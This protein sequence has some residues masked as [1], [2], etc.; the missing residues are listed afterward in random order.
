[1]LQNFRV[2][3]LTWNVVGRQPI[4]DLQL[5][6]GLEDPIDPLTLPD[7]YIVGLQE[8]SSK[9][10]DRVIDLLFDDPWA[11]AIKQILHP[12]DY[13]KVK[14]VRLQGIILLFFCKRTHLVHLRRTQT[15][16]TRTGF[17][18]VWG[19]KGG[20]SIRF[21]VYSCSVCVVNCHFAPH[22]KELQQRIYEYNTIVDSQ[23]FD[24]PQ[25]KNILMHDYV[26]WMGDLNF[27]IDDMLT[28]EMKL[29]IEREEFA[30]L[31]AKDQLCQIR[32]TGEAFSEFTEETPTF[33][34]TYRFIIDSDEYDYLNRRPAWTDRILY[35]FTQ[36]AYDQVS[37]DLE[38]HHYK[39]YPY[40]LQSDHK[41]VSSAFSIKVFS[42]PKEDLIIFL[43]IQN[44]KINTDGIACYK[45]VGAD[46]NSWDWIALYRVHFS[47]IDEY[48]CYVWASTKPLVIP[49]STPE[50]E[51]LIVSTQENFTRAH[52]AWLQ[53]QVTF[54]DHNILL[55]GTYQ[56]LY[57][58]SSFDN[59]LGMSEPFEILRG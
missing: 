36:N 55:P 35:H 7:V 41:P 21:N 59:V 15:A 26:F 5:A 49:S 52:C 6:L 46:I 57:I 48:L 13:V 9:P 16:Y 28:E 2:Y 45:T 8:V 43:P 22:D 17:G 18:G 27:R 40:Y 37:L 34:P 58:S 1:M 23:T 4:E 47:S 42:E 54:A 31:L 53:Y 10:Y 20:V 25:S 56:L 12:W 39:S 11:N 19:N 29:M 38:Q 24:D 3:L 14:Q 44:W 33:P 30:P 50:S 32:K 51:D